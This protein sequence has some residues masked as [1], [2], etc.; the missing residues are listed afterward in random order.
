MD[1]RALL[2][3]AGLGAFLMFVLDPDRGGRR[4]ALMRDKVVR[5]GRLARDGADATFR[6]MRQRAAG[7]MHEAR[8]RMQSD[9]VDDQTLV[10][11]VRARLGRVCSHPRAIDV[12]ATEGNVTLRGPILAAEVENVLGVAGAVR[13]VRTVNNELE[14]HDTSAGVPSLQGHG[15]VAG[16]SIDIL[17]RNWAPATR[18]IVGLA[19]VAAAGG[20]AAAYRRH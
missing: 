2:A 11:R 9:E 7:I 18:A 4:R 13:G 8:G 19:A 20:V 3:G 5:G 12:M 16:P 15:R 14:P 1:T 17:Q 6:D 10:E